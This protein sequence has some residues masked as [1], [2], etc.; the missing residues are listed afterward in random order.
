MEI[1]LG[2]D[3]K[4]NLKDFGEADFKALADGLSLPAY[5]GRQ[6][7][8]WIFGK[9]VFTFDE[10]TDLPLDLRRTLE[11]GFFIGRLALESAETSRDATR[12]FLFL[13]VS[14]NWNVPLCRH[15][16][17]RVCS[18][19]G[20]LNTPMCLCRRFPGSLP[21]QLMAGKSGKSPDPSVENSVKFSTPLRK[22]PKL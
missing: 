15:S 20:P 2:P 6:I 4:K 18:P 16:N 22:N 12:K 19:L 5:R 7:A 3:S 1:F 11:D 9:R 21:V 13:Q 10:M 14:K 17:R 8:K